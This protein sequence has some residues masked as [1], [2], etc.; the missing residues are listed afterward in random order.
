MDVL[1]WLGSVCK[2]SDQR[3]RC[4]DVPVF[5]QLEPRLLLSG[6]GFGVEYEGL[7]IEDDSQPVIS[8]DINPVLES[9]VNESTAY[10][11]DILEYSYGNSGLVDPVYAVEKTEDRGQTTDDCL[12]GKKVGGEEEGR[13]VS[14]QQAEV[15]RGEIQEQLCERQEDINSQRI[16]NI[17]HRIMNC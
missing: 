7:L 5:E 3:S 17:E 11:S 14:S 10:E 12:E 15:R 2:T 6:E 9:T 4:A 16:S 13:A 1:T 8:A